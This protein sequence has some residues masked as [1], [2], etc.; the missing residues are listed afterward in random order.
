MEASME[1]MEASVEVTSTEGFRGSFNGSYF[2]GSYFH[3][4]AS[5]KVSTEITSTE[6]SIEYF[7]D[8]N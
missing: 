6:T 2:H 1:A 7:V 5:V 8:V 3:G 4:K